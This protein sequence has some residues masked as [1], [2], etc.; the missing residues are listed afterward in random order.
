LNADTAAVLPFHRRQLPA[1]EA[2][3][4]FRRL[5]AD[6]DLLAERPEARVKLRRNR[7]TPTG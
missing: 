6:Y 1:P 3:A 4:T 2:S 7:E 5:G